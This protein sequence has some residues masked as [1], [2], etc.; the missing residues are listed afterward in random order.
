MITFISPVRVNRLKLLLV[1]YRG[2][3]VAKT[4]V[5]L[6][7]EMNGQCEALQ[8]LFW[9]KSRQFSKL[10]QANSFWN[11]LFPLAVSPHKGHT[12]FSALLHAHLP[13]S[14]NWMASSHYGL[15]T[16]SLTCTLSFTPTPHPEKY[17][18]RTAP[19][20]HSHHHT[21]RWGTE[22]M[23]ELD[24]FCISLY[25]IFQENA[26]DSTFKMTRKNGEHYTC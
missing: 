13:F 8:H 2:G 4:H 18:Q 5:T 19:C 6:I 11:E 22:V 1:S 16:L 21:S 9:W 26:A 25:L 10:V 3:A 24:L 14:L 23:T 17:R 12:S 15:S 7:Q 20:R